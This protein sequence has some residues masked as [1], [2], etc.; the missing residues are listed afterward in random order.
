MNI[1]FLKNEYQ[2]LK[3]DINRMFITDNMNELHI[4]FHLAIPDNVND[5]F[6]KFFLNFIE[7]NNYDFDWTWN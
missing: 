2:M 3:G 1:I 6:G 4:E 5:S 7:S